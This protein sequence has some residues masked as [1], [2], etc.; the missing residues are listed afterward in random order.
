MFYQILLSPQVK[1]WA[2]ITYKHGIYEL[3]NELLNDVTAHSPCQNES[4][5]STSR[6][7][8]KNRNQ[9]LPTRHENQ[10]QSGHPGHPAPTKAPTSSHSPHQ[11][12]PSH[13]DHAHTTPNS[14][15][16]TGPPKPRQPMHDTKGKTPPDATCS[17]TLQ[18]SPIV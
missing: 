12:K 14:P 15:R 3:L 10:S 18:R 4:F 8:L 11:S 9:T 13:H 5:L 17:D 1:Q 2:I 7:F 16:T 6:R